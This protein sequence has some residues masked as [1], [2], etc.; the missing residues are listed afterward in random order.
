MAFFSFEV[1][2]PIPPEPAN[3]ASVKKSSAK[4]CSSTS[5]KKRRVSEILNDFSHG[6]IVSAAIRSFQNQDKED[7]SHIL[8]LLLEKPDDLDGIQ[9]YL[10]KVKKNKGKSPSIIKPAR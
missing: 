4:A 7:A 1:D 2:P 9:K 5:S 10:H 3:S 8:K 6:C